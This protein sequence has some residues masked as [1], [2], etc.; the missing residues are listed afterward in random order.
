[1]STLSARFIRR[2][3]QRYVCDWC[4]RAILG[5][6]IRLYGLFNEHFKPY[7]LLAH[8]G[9]LSPETNDA[10]VQAALKVARESE[11]AV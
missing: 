8:V 10:K 1:M 3:R 2:P 7:T 11:V 5:P 4:G 9:C 6:Y